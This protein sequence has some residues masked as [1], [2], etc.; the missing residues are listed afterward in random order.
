MNKSLDL[1]SVT[2]TLKT[3]L[4]VLHIAMGRVTLTLQFPVQKKIFLLSLIQSPAKL[5]EKETLAM[6]YILSSQ[7]EMYGMNFAL[8]DFKWPFA[9]QVYWRNN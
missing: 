8:Y 5:C 6:Y 7:R 9:R 1:H 4:T 3:C 2:E